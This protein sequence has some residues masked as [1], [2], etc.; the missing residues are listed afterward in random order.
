MFVFDLA[1]EEIQDARINDRAVC[2][3]RIFHVFFEFGG[4][5]GLDKFLT[6]DESASTIWSDTRE[7]VDRDL[8]L[9]HNSRLNRYPLNLIF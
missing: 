4:R 2:R 9:E 5:G 8:L 7:A 6:G 3:R 1:T